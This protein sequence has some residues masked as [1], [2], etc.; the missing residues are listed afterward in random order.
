MTFNQAAYTDHLAQTG[1]GKKVESEAE[2]YKPKSHQLIV[3]R[4]KEGQALP[5]DLEHER[6][7]SIQVEGRELLYDHHS[8]RE[9]QPVQLYRDTFDDLSSWPFSVTIFFY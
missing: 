1:H 9:K 3:V 4:L 7:V 5:A 8:H 2:E 6:P